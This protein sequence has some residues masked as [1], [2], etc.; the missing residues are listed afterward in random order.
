MDELRIAIDP[1]QHR[2]GGRPIAWLVVPVLGAGRP[3]Q[4]RE[5]A[6][7]ACVL[8]FG[9]GEMV[10]DLDTGFTFRCDSVE[11]PA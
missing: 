6:V 7:R 5:A 1:P 3:E 2:P 4:L 11:L 10:G 8:E 9:P